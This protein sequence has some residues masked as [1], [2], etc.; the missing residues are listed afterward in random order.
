MTLSWSAIQ[1]PFRYP[2]T[3]S[4][5]TKTH[6]PALI[7]RLEHRGLVGYGEAP[8]ITYYDITVER[9][10]ADLQQRLPMIER[11]AFTDPER[12]WH[13]LH[14]L[15]PADPF[16]VCALDIAGWDLFGKMCRR[17]LLEYW[18]LDPSKAPWTDYTIGIDTE[19]RIDRKSTRLN[20]SHT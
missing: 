13:F 3:I 5:G 9:M 4:K 14:H 16:L 19:E 10:I 20:S 17:P 15:I 11:F 8:A 6:Q 18:E 7:V 12:F 2:F 1:L